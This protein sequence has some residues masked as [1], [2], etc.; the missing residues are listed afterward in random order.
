MVRTVWDNRCVP[1]VVLSR[2]KGAAVVD[3][4][5]KDAGGVGGQE[6]A[7]ESGGGARETAAR[8]KDGERR[9]RTA[10]EQSQT[11]SRG[12]TRSPQNQHA[13]R[14]SQCGATP[15]RV[16]RS[17]RGRLR[18]EFS[19]EFE[20]ERSS[21]ESLDVPRAQRDSKTSG[22]AGRREVR[23]TVVVVCGREVRDAS[24]RIWECRRWCVY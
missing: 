16:E 13:V 9:T 8:D 10:S 14:D 19:V 4:D 22:R 15:S 20:D 18:S 12:H 17:P 23:G 6:L 1:F 24:V 5:A 21:R 3:G 11:S 7:Q 2:V